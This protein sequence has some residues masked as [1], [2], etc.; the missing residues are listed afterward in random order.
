[1]FVR[2]SARRHRVLGVFG[3]RFVGAPRAV[4]VM[5]VPT[6]RCRTSVADPLSPTA[7]FGSVLLYGISVFQGPSSGRRSISGQR[8]GTLKRAATEWVGGE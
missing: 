1:M 4:G 2:R 6:A 8:F 5:V 3:N 7:L